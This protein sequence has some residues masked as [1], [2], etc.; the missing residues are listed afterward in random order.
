MK[1]ILLVIL[2]APLFTFGQDTLNVNKEQR[3]FC[4]NVIKS[5]VEHNCDEYFESMSDTVVVY[6]SV[7]DTM[8]PKSILK[9]YVMM[10]CNAGVRNDSLDF[11]YYLDNFEIK[12]YDVNAIA[13]KIGRGRGDKESNLATLNYYH[14]QEG[15]IYFQGA[16]HKSRNRM[17]FILDDAF[18]FIFRKINGRYK[19]LVITP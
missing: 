6:R 8:L 3:D 11:Q 12:F 13:D 18:Q 19:V 5:I 7:R 9:P 16:Y 17:D 2:F 1:K 10:L 14:I 4:L 15:D